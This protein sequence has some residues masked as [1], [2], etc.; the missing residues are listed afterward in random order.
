MIV[1]FAHKGLERF[2]RTGLTAGIQA[3]HAKKLRAI[4]IRLNAARVIDD[5]N[6][7][8]SKL[9]PLKGDKKGLWALSVNANW[10]ITFVFDGGN[11]DIVDYVDYH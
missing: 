6:Y 3:K 11:V 8:G 10:R 5:M 7:S 4:L 9:H 1:G 2:Y